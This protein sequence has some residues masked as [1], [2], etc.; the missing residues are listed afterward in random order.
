MILD[1]ILGVSLNVLFEFVMVPIMCILI[2]PY[3]LIRAMFGQG[4]YIE[5]MGATYTRL[6]RFL[7]RK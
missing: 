5:K 3:V 7:L 1:A 2:T 4:A 6:I